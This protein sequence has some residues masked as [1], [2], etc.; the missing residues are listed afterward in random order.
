MKRWLKVVLILVVVCVG[1]ILAAGLVLRSVVS[2]SGKDRLIASLGE[3]MGVPVSVG[4]VN[5][6][7]RKLLRFR[8]AVALDNVT[9][10]NPPGFHAKDLLQAKRISAQVALLPL[11]HKSVEVQ[12]IVVDQPRIVV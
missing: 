4:S 3:K 10:G 12:S 6:D 11:F 7:I 2:G 9:V 8:P 5:L 1:L